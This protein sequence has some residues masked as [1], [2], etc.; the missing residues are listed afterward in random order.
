[1][2]KLK[3]YCKFSTGGHG[4]NPDI[5]KRLVEEASL[6]TLIEFQK[7]VTLIFDEMQI[8]S[9]L[10]YKRSTG[11]LI[12]F[13]AMGGVSEEFRIFSEYVKLDVH[14]TQVESSDSA[15]K[16]QRDIA[17]HVIVYMVQRLFTNLCYPFAYFAS[18]GF[19]SAQLYPCTMEATQVLESLGFLVRAFASDGASPNRKFYNIV[20][21]GV[22]SFYFTRNAFDRRRRIYLISD[23]PHLLKTT[24]NCFENSCWNKNTRNLHVCFSVFQYF[25]I[26]N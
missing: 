2:N 22:D 15:K 1:M 12:G 21:E 19:T 7:Y 14:D 11:K 6:P 3:Q 25:F 5:L 18:T 4:F 9:N 17:T 26:F 16:Y 23:V 10:V 13:T 20:S 24:R 8:K